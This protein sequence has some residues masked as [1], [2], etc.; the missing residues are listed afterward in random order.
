MSTITARPALRGRHA[1]PANLVHSAVRSI[2]QENESYKAVGDIDESKESVSWQMTVS[3]VNY[4]H[5]MEQK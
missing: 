4:I 3:F 1:Y 2:I 5:L